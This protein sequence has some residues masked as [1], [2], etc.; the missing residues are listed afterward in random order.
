MDY[1]E[2]I[3]S[4]KKISR[5]EDFNDAVSQLQATIYEMDKDVLLPISLNIGTIPENIEHDSTE[6]KLYSKVTDIVLSKCFQ[7]LG[8]KSEVIQ[9]RANCADVVARSQYHDYSLVADAKAF[10]LSR[11]AKNQKDFKVQS[12]VN[13]KGTHNYAVLVGPYFQYPRNRSQIYS[14]ALDGNVCLIS[15][16]LL[17]LFIDFG[18]TET[19]EINLS[20]IWNNSFLMSET[21]TM[22][23]RFQNFFQSTFQLI[24][25]DYDIS[26]DKITGSLKDFGD[27]ITNRA[28]E[29]I[30]YWE[31]RKNEIKSY[32]K[33]RAINELID[34]MKMN[35]KIDQIRQFK[36]TMHSDAD[37]SG[38]DDE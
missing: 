5:S 10:R 23:N 29:A 38:E 21:I 30:G 13:W 24:E 16:E 36:E 22:K 20:K 7:M 2:L 4:I 25:E 33:E 3:G 34:A 31:N 15:W 9:S 26:M 18:L 37:E 6:E 8:L 27:S 12:M 32:D 14:Q 11:S 1:S 17:Y 35:Q 28:D 19:A